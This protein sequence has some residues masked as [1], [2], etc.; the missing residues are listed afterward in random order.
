MKNITTLIIC[1]IIYSN[2]SAQNP[3]TL[4][5][6]FNHK[7]P[8]E[9]IH[10]HFDK[11]VYVAGETIWF[12][13]YLLS[14]LLPDTIS[15]SVI[16]DLVDAT[17]RLYARK[18]LPVFDGTAT[19]NFDLPD[20]LKQGNF[21]V[22][23][24][25]GWMLNFDPG[26]LYSKSIFIFNNKPATS[27]GAKDLSYTVDFFP[28]GGNMVADV[29]NF[30]AFKG[31]NAN[32]HPVSFTG[33]IIDSKGNII[34]DLS[35]VHSG[36]G[37]FT[38]LPQADEI[39]T[40]KLK[41]DNGNVSSMQI[42]VGH[43]GIA[44]HVDNDGKAIR[45]LLSRSAENV[46]DKLSFSV[47]GQM[48]NHTLFETSALLDGESVS[49]GVPTT[50]FP[51][52]ILQVTVF[53]ATGKP[54]LERL[55]FVNNQEYEI[56][57]N[58]TPDTLGLGKKAKNVFTFSVPDSIEGTYSVAITDANA[59]V[60][61]RNADNIV[62][63]FLLSSDIKGY[64]EN[65]AW[66]FF[67]N[68][69]ATR[70]ALDLVMMTNG[71]RR[72]NWGQIISGQMP[73][74]TFRP[75]PYLRISGKAYAENKK[76]VL[77]GGDLNFIIKA[78][79]DSAT[80]FVTVP[81]DSQGNFSLDSLIFKDT[82]AFYFNYN[83]RNK[84]KKQVFL[85]LDAVASAPVSNNYVPPAFYVT[86]DIAFDSLQ[87]KM[88]KNIEQVKFYNAYT[89][90]FISLE[91][92]K[93]KVKKKSPTQ[94][95]NERYTSSIF[96]T[97]SAN[98]TLDLITNP[99]PHI[100]NLLVYIRNQIP[101]IDIIGIPGNQKIVSNIATSLTGGKQEVTIYVDQFESDI[102]TIQYIPIDEIALIKFLKN[103]VYSNT[104]G[105]ALLI[106]RKT[107]GDMAGSP[108]NYVS[109]FTYPGYS[110]TKEFYS[111]NYSN[112]GANT[113]APDIRT[114][115]YWNPNVVLD[116]NKQKELF[117]FYNSDNCKR[118][119]VVIE[120]FNKAGRLCRLEKEYGR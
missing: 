15:S 76:D 107:A 36:M 83:T 117:K 40:A 39:Y 49:I 57:S 60:V 25:T 79:S 70:S 84:S 99:V 27:S 105:P 116:I 66:Y 9:K 42:P 94:L 18:N 112:P 23:G 47:V 52:G 35:T 87:M 82:A 41:F 12:K 44:M 61:D 98:T 20:S 119:R 58:L 86:E 56:S 101:G 31:T 8:Q 1:S 29:V 63:R 59:S 62:S 3:V 77:T 89:A 51:S 110:V 30:V 92:I 106:Y 26:F 114:T 93:I 90:K 7:Y 85:K 78:K 81:I 33:T 2:I 109:S 32:G 22:H 69:R 120:G 75:L 38:L 73:E 74:I 111:P 108:S 68:D 64:V 19:G 16:V 28:E 46:K 55:T 65:P 4:L 80:D 91:E 102:T 6:D 103:F 96:S 71:W 115:L 10:L 24:Y 72:F 118:M 5:T 14:N 17:G 48:E 95:V 113:D 43:P 34:T 45:V 13:V 100:S 11:D 88:T 37:R 97:P 50:N 53:D 67:G 54:I 21:T 104:N